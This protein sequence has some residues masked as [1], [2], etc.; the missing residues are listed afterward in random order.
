MKTR[1]KI[2]EYCSNLYMS[3]EKEYGKKEK[4]ILEPSSGGIGIKLNMPSARFMSTM[5]EVMK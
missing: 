3:D 4:R 2:K 5:I 1:S